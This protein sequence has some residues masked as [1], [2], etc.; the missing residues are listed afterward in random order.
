MSATAYLMFVSGLALELLVVYR[1]LREM[2]WYRYPF[3]FCYAVYLV[4]VTIAVFG[5]LCFRPVLYAKVYWY[6]ECANM[7]LRFLV[8]W[9]VFRHIFRRSSVLHGIVSKG[10]MFGVLGM[11]VV[12]AG[13]SWG[14]ENYETSHSVWFAS[15]RTLG[16]CQASLILA[17]LFLARYYNLHLGRNLWG[18][19][20]GFGLFSSFSIVNFALIDLVPSFFPYWQLITPFGAV[21]MLG[22]WTWAIWNYSPNQVV[23]NGTFDHSDIERWSENWSR[24]LSVIRRVIH[25]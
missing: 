24:T 9:E 21:S 19:A 4:T 3:F 25:P 20:V 2:S 8:I 11:I 22:M 10:F 6:G 17:I 13:I 23:T 12:L 7:F 18:V 1:L 15:E 16:L 5:I 14:A